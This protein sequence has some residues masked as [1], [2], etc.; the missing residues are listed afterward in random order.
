MMNHMNCGFTL[1]ELLIVVAIIGL[2]AAIAVPN[3]LNAQTRAKL[4][5]C[6]SDMK[7]LGTAIDLYRQDN[8]HYPPQHPEGRDSSHYVGGNLKNWAR[9][10]PLTAPMAYMSALPADPFKK[11]PDQ[12]D[13]FG[14]MT[15]SYAVK[16]DRLNNQAA[17][18][19]WSRS[20]SEWVL[21]GYGPNQTWDWQFP[22]A[23]TNGLISRGNVL[24]WGPGNTFGYPPSG[25]PF[26]S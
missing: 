19:T 15:Y 4:A 9:L 25:R 8:N 23:V 20:R 14:P 16:Y 5:R 13:E 21:D 24:L 6:M 18:D 10:F 22:Y 11:Y 7:A 1:I 2:L 12:F 3:F 26:G 17:I